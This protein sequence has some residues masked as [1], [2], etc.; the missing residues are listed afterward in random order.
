M[1]RAR[2]V[3]ARHDEEVDVPRHGDA[4]HHGV[5]VVVVV[6]R[7]DEGSLGGH[8]LEPRDLEAE[9]GTQQGRA[10]AAQEPVEGREAGRARLSGG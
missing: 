5:E 6:G 2:V 8:V 10:G 1:Q 4:Q 9:H 3:D 7:E